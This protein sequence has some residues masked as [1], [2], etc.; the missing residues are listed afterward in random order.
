MKPFSAAKSMGRNT[1]SPNFQREKTL[2]VYATHTLSARKSVIYGIFST[3]EKRIVGYRSV[4][5]NLFIRMLQNQINKKQ[6]LIIK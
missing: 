5:N 1:P 3:G 4:Y 6:G 2:S